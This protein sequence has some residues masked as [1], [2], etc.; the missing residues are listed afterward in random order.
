MLRRLPWCIFEIHV[1]VGI[2]LIRLPSK[3]SICRDDVTHK[4]TTGKET[5]GRPG[6]EKGVRTRFEQ[7]GGEETHGPSGASHTRRCRVSRAQLRERATG[8]V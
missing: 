4:F 2:L 5:P 1:L 8:V 3:S 7:C 6:K